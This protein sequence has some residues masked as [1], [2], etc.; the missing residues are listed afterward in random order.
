MPAESKDPVYNLEQIVLEFYPQISYRVKK[1]I[2]FN[3]PEWEDICSEIII[4]VLEVLK[5]GKFRG[6]KLFGNIY[7]YHHQPQ[8]RGSHPQKNPHAQT[9]S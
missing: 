6:R 9:Y 1:S 5:S 8:D 4:S 2:G 3:N 7:L